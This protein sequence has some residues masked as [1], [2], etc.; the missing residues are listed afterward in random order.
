MPS[1]VRLASFASLMM[2]GI[3]PI[4]I[5]A[6]MVLPVPGVARSI[7]KTVSKYVPKGTRNMG[8]KQNLRPSSNTRSQK[9]H[10]DERQADMDAQ[11][12][13]EK[14]KEAVSRW[15]GQ[16]GT[17]KS[18][19]AASAGF[20]H[21]TT[22]SDSLHRMLN[23]INQ[24]ECTTRDPELLPAGNQLFEEGSHFSRAASHPHACNGTRRQSNRC[25]NSIDHGTV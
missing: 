25:R 4:I 3:L 12:N 9:V 6:M 22:L 11:S 5:V 13:A 19:R 20:V 2:P 16:G 17:C 14:L 8:I 1:L 21:R 7:T 10:N 15:H 23:L 18:M 24:E